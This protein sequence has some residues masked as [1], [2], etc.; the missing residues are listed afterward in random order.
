MSWTQY[1]RFASFSLYAYI[2]THIYTLLRCSKD[3]QKRRYSQNNSG[4]SSYS[5]NK[6]CCVSWQT[7]TLREVPLEDN[8]G[9]LRGHLHWSPALVTC[10]GHLH[11]SPALVTCT[12]DLHRSPALVTCSCYQNSNLILWCLCFRL[13]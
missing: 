13:L 4:L 3:P 10:T 9:V 5:R 8:G 11:W 6:L 2:H 12:G 1:I 7:N